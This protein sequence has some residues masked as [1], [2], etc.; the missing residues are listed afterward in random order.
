MPE[1]A[2]PSGAAERRTL[3]MV[4][5]QEDFLALQPRDRLLARSAVR[6]P[7]MTWQLVQRVVEPALAPVPP[8]DRRG[9]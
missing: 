2:L 8:A 9:G 6:T 7:F 5:N 1:K 4:G 3:R